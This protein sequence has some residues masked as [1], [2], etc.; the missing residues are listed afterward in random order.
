M[1]KLFK[2]L[3]GITLGLALCFGFSFSV[4]NK[5]SN[6]M[7]R[8]VNGDSLCGGD[9]SSALP[10]D[11][12][13][14]GT[15]TYSGNGIKFDGAGDYIVSPDISSYSLKNVKVSLKA[16]HNNGKGSVLT[17]AALDASS[18][19]LD[20]EDFTPTEAYTSQN[21]VYDFELDSTSTIS[22]VKISM[23]SKTKNLGMKYCEVFDNTPSGGSTKLTAPNLTFDRANSQVTWASVE[24]A[25]SYDLSID[26]GEA[27]HNATSPYSISSYS[28][29]EVH[30]ASITAIGDGTNY[31]NSS[32]S[33]VKFAVFGHDGT[34]EDPFTVPEAKLLI[35]I[36][37]GLTDTVCATGKV[38]K[39][40]KNAGSR[41][42]NG[43]ISYYISTDGTTSDELEAYNGKGLNGASFESEDEIQIGD[44]VVI[45]GKLKKYNSTYEFDANN[46]LVSLVRP[47][48]KELDSVVIDGTMTKT[49]YTSNQQWDPSGITV[50]AVYDDDSSVDV[51]DKVTWSY[52]YATPA[53]MG[54]TENPTQLEVTAHYMNDYDTTYVMVTV[55][56]ASI[57]N[58]YNLGGEYH[59]YVADNT[60]GAWIN[61]GSEKN[62]K[63][64]PYGVSEESIAGVY[65]LTLVDD[66][67][68]T[69]TLGEKYLYSTAENNGI[70]I[71]SNP[72]DES[73]KWIVTKPGD[74]YLFNNKKQSTRYLS[75]YASGNDIRSYAATDKAHVT[76]S[77][78][79]TVTG[80]S[81]YSEGANKNV[82]IGSTFDATA[83]AQ[84][85]FQARLNYD[86]NS[87]TDVTSYATW[88]LDTSTVGT[89][90]LTVTYPSYPSVTFDDMNVYNVVFSALE[91]DASNAKTTG[92]FLGDSLDTNGLVIEGNDG[93]GNLYPIELENVTFS[94]TTLETV[95][96]Q[97]I[98]VS[99]TNDNNTVATG[100]YSVNV[101]EFVGYDKATS[102]SDINVGSAYVVASPSNGKVMGPLSGEYM[103]SLSAVFNNSYSKVYSSLPTGT[104]TV[105]FLSAGDGLYNMYDIENN[106]YFYLNPNGSKVGFVN[107]S[108]EATDL[109][110]S[111]DDNGQ[112]TI[113]NNV[114]KVDTNV[115]RVL[116]FNYNNGNGPRFASYESSYNSI[117]LYKVGNSSLVTSVTG[118][119]NEYLK[120]NDS[121]YDGDIETPECSEN[122]EYLKMAY[123]ELT[124]VQK[125]ILQYNDDF[126]AARARLNA[127]ATANGET[128]TYGAEQP[129]HKSL[130]GRGIFGD[131]IFAE[132][133]NNTTLIL[134][135]IATLG[136]GALSA[137]YLVRKR[138]RAQ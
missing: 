101:A 51:T 84:A 108:E 93:N 80:F 52:N 67:T 75:Y 9:M 49:T 114:A 105:T 131:N 120:M 34:E 27:I 39:F 135:I 68:F 113:Q 116:G 18:N 128:F 63:G 3:T 53:E 132:D 89:K 78:P 103:S 45:K 125:N 133:D 73:E 43:Q 35:D 83:A 70:R 10:S 44:V 26:G 76:L 29:G 20:S 57:V 1:N 81:V 99:Y 38:S 64:A 5:Q 98:T 82:L 15:G 100:T 86:D 32:A 110:I 66:D 24:N 55:E 7:A 136:A 96:T 92:Y 62:S 65:T 8:A 104:V 111:F 97:T 124:E 12:T 121:N 54:V 95:G 118:F 127:W 56:E 30:T 23:K 4:S 106:R 77:V 40:F 59:I 2:G 134:F 28:S 122:Y 91:I 60:D 129:F 130:N 48:E 25:S 138:K 41:I 137:F 31:T 85:G 46:E 19:V 126:A 115:K 90:T 123:D 16:G 36:T 21:T 17:I 87:F 61:D 11:W 72:N 69:I 13:N 50:Y 6:Q 94:P 88:S 58:T 14:S 107:S 22:F 102:L 74:Y 47:G 119:V 33:T 109:T 42:S 71:D 37:D 79:K 112:I 117:A